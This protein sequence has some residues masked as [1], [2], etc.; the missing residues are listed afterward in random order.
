MKLTLIPARFSF[1]LTTVVKK[2]STPSLA[3][4]EAL[5]IALYMVKSDA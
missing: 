5:T 3:S 4:G 2:S 1:S